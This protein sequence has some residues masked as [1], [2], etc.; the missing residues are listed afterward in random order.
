M[1]VNIQQIIYSLP[2]YSATVSGKST[3]VFYSN[4]QNSTANLDLANQCTAW[5]LVHIPLIKL[6]WVNISEPV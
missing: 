3:A 5:T 1:S 6:Q 4:T 2:N